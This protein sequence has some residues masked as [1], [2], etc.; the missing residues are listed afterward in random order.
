MCLKVH[1]P[2]R[3]KAGLTLIEILISTIILVTVIP[4]A[5]MAF[6]SAQTMMDPDLQLQV[7]MNRDEMEVLNTSVRW[8]QWNQAGTP[9]WPGANKITT[10]NSA[11]TGFVGFTR[12]D[13]VEN[14]TGQ[15]DY[16]K[17]RVFTPER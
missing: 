6:E 3:K 9:L 15:K 7:N 17:V 14:M 10:P 11:T 13:T 4:L 1:P 8:D 5:M 12:T 2:A 16:R